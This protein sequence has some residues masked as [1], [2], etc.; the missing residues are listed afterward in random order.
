[1][2]NPFTRKLQSVALLSR[3]D[4][5][6]V[7]TLLDREFDVA[8]R[9]DLIREGDKPTHIR[10]LTSGFACRAKYQPEGDRQIVSF[11]VPR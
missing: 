5:A 9:T 8:A 7:D 3:S 6:L 10:L 4:I 1:M 2:S 11:L